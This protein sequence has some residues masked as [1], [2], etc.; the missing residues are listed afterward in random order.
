MSYA[1]LNTYERGSI[2]ILLAVGKSNAQI[3]KRLGRHKETIR[4]ER[5]RLGAHEAYT[6][7]EAQ[8]NYKHKRTASKPNGKATDEIV[9]IIEK[10]LELTWS[11]EQIANTVAKGKASTKTIYN[12]MDEGKLPH[13][14]VS[15]LRQKGKRKRPID[16][17]G[18]FPK[19]TPI[20]ERPEQIETREEFGH[21][22]LD[23]VVS[24]K[25]QSKNCL[26]TFIE[27][28]SRLYTAL[29]IPD[30]T[31][32]SML[33]AIKYLCKCLPINAFK[34]ATTDRG[35]EF[36]CHQIVENE[37]CIPVYF[38]DAYSCS[39]ENANGLLREFYPKRTDFGKVE[40]EEISYH[41]H[42]INSRP[43]KC[44]AWKS[45]QEVFLEEVA[46]LA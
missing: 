14:S 37:L 11:P 42:L 8:L 18:T 32:A 40:Q 30:R 41:L 13:V 45:A 38:A 44:L 19:G 23:T 27:R 36:A 31:S 17:R 15:Q 7:H 26:A 25:G 24:G 22:E 12:W 20:A 29:S 16:A 21:W 1:H 28:K 43:R 39:N 10:H 35:R 33:G 5:M 2:A 34:S 6:P 46:H 4:R 3:A 9:S